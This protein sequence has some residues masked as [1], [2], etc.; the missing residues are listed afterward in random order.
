MVV[1][2]H[3]CFY[4]HCYD[5]IISLRGIRL[6]QFDDCPPPLAMGIFPSG[7]WIIFNW[8]LLS[9]LALSDVVLARH[10]I[11]TSETEWHEAICLAHETC[12]I[13]ITKVTGRMNLHIMLLSCVMHT[14]CSVHL[15]Y[16]S[17]LIS[18]LIARFIGPTW[19]HLGMTGPRWAPCWPHEPCHLGSFP[20]SRFPK[21]TTLLLTMYWWEINDSPAWFWGWMYFITFCNIP[22]TIHPIF[23][24]YI[25]TKSVT[26]TYQ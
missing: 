14:Y 10:R 19:A 17:P 8:I 23:M 5:D 3:L 13:N 1:Q 24:T 20:I 26:H 16:W 4:S 25:H 22:L 15:S 7:Y 21:W 12:C 9:D 2:C 11:I 18:T 6:Q